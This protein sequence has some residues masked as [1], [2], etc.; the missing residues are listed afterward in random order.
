M[1]LYGADMKL[2]FYAKEIQIK[3]SIIEMA[4]K[5]Y[6]TSCMARSSHSHK[7]RCYRRLALHSFGRTLPVCYSKRKEKLKT[8]YGIQMSS[9]I[10]ACANE[11]GIVF[12]KREFKSLSIIYDYWAYPAK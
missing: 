10:M 3:I 1:N 9:A 6:L 8:K 4:P 5:R 7:P 12:E 11:Y 2:K